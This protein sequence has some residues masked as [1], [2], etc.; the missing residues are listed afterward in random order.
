MACG[1]GVKAIQIAAE[2][3]MLGNASVVVAGGQENM[4]RTPF[5]LDRMRVGY[6]MGDAPL[7]DGMNR[8]GFLDTLCGL[9]MGATAENLAQRYGI[10]GKDQDKFR[11]RPQEEDAPLLDRRAT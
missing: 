3:I 9:I 4:T 11:L 5:L 8:D 10:P 7:Y 1:S 6:R 2:Q